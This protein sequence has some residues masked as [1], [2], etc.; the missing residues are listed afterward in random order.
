MNRPM[1]IARIIS[2]IIILLAFTASVWLA[3]GVSHAAEIPAAKKNSVL[4]LKDQHIVVKNSSGQQ[5]IV[6][7]DVFGPDKECIANSRQWSNFRIVKST[8]NAKS[9]DS[10][11][12]PEIFY[13]CAWG[14]CTPDS[15]LPERVSNASKLKATWQTN[16]HASGK[17][18]VAF[19]FWFMKHKHI[20]GQ[21]KGAEIMIWLNS[22]G[23]NVS[24]LPEVRIDG[25][26]WH[27][28]N[29][30]ACSSVHHGCWHYILFHRAKAVSGVKDLKLNPFFKYAEHRGLIRK[31]WYITSC[32][33]GFEIWHG[34]VGLSTKWFRIFQ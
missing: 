20:T 16:Q 19:D 29:H 5:F 14:V 30:T 32:D 31:N 34:G 33:A 9:V 10:V 6:R 3:V 18:N 22:R 2:Y 27:F 24:A 13:G 11:A 21:A 23:F 8:A 1:R 7:N 26:L 12:F 4:C 25:A 15:K 28:A 17:W